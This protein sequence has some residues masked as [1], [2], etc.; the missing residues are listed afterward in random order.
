MSGPRAASDRGRQA[1]K[2]RHIKIENFRAIAL[3][4]HSFTD[5]LGRVRDTTLLVGPNG[6]GKTSILDAIAA[7]FNPLTRINALRPGLELSPK[8][9]VRHGA[10]FA[11]VEAEVGF[12]PTE[13]ET[14]LRVL[15]LSGTTLAAEAGGIRDAGV[16]SFS[17]TYPDP[18]EQLNWG[19]FDC[20][21]K[22]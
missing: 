18:Q 11:R 5:S 16:V 10:A 17:W 15:S 9:I 12:A 3:W 8:R 19:R 6:S 22:E 1:M 20:V 14:A 2:L 7:A 4:E 21:P 13:I